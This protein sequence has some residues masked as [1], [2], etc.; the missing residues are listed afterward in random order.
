MRELFPAAYGSSQPFEVQV[1][2]TFEVVSVPE[3]DA[4]QAV[5]LLNHFRPHPLGA[6]LACHGEW[7]LILP[8]GSAWQMEWPQPHW[9]YM[10]DG[11]LLVPSLSAP[12]HEPLHWVRTGNAEGRVFSAPM[13]LHAALPLLRPAVPLLSLVPSLPDVRI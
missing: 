6:A 4:L 11:L 12:E 3:Q 5:S 1:G 8:P 13:L 10:A 7:T 2:E 9:R